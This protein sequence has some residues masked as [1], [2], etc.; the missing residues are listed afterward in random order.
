MHLQHFS[1]KLL[2]LGNKEGLILF[3]A[4]G[5]WVRYYDLK[6]KKYGKGR[7]LLDSRT[8]KQATCFKLGL[9]THIL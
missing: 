8:G 2:I 5:N 9:G 1:L 6:T 7:L 4:L 3:L